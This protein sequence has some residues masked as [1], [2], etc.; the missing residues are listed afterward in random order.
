MEQW[1]I[2]YEFLSRIDFSRFRVITYM[3]ELFLQCVC[4][5]VL[6]QNVQCLN[7]YIKG[8]RILD[9][10]SKISENNKCKKDQMYT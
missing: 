4:R 2:L 5:K 1:F 7:T 9:Y 6:L 8:K 10:V 3:F